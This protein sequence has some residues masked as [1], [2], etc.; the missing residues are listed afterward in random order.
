MTSRHGHVILFSTSFNH[1][2]GSNI[3]MFG[4]FRFIQMVWSHNQYDFHL[5]C[6]VVVSVLLLC[7]CVCVEIHDRNS[8][9]KALFNKLTKYTK[10]YD[11]CNIVYVYMYMSLC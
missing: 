3:I 2:V 9:N 11:I 10:Y 6:V 1:L 5:G 7:V 4:A 8:S